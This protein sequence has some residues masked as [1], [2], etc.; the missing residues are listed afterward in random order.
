M[1]NIMYNDNKTVQ[2]STP[3][4]TEFNNSIFLLVPD[5]N[6]YWASAIYVYFIQINLNI[7]VDGWYP[8]IK[9]NISQGIHI[10]SKLPNERLQLL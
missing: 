1:K 6:C 4:A 8:Q 2:L 7:C 10:A 5:L 3:N 9:E